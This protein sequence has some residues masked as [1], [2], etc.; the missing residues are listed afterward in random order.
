LSTTG[1]YDPNVAVTVPEVSRITLLWRRIWNTIACMKAAILLCILAVLSS[2]QSRAQDQGLAQKTPTPG[3]WIDPSTG[4]MWAAKDNGK[5]LSWR[6]AMKYCH[7]LRLNGNSDWRLANVAEMQGIYDKSVNALGLVGYSKHLRPFTWHVKGSLFLTGKQWGGHPV[8]GRMP[9][10]SYEFHFDFFQ[11][12]ID[13]DPS[14]WPYPSSG[15]RALC[16]RG[17]ER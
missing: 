1:N 5:D 14:G 11:G 16:V 13:K 12:S 4:L 2:N 8:S 17:T 6:K 3:Y 10:E 15:I 9:L 7:N